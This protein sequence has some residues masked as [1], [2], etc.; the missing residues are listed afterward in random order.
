MYGDFSP[1]SS[2]DVTRQHAGY[3]F[4]TLET[5]LF[6][7][8]TESQ[9]YVHAQLAFNVWDAWLKRKLNIKILLVSMKPLIILR[10]DPEATS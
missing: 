8:K 2:V 3:Y 7:N 9:L 5:S 10:I 6:L 1:N 4:P